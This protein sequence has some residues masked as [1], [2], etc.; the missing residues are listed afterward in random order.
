MAYQS[1]TIFS[2]MSNMI[3][4]WKNEWNEVTCTDDL[5][6]K[7]D[8]RDNVQDT[9][10][11][12]TPNPNNGNQS[13]Q[14]IIINGV[15]ITANQLLLRQAVIK[16]SIPE[17]EYKKLTTQERLIIDLP[18]IMVKLGWLYS[19]YCQI[20]WLEASGSE[21][22]VP[23]EFVTSYTRVQKTYRSMLN[24]FAQMEYASINEFNSLVK[25]SFNGSA[26]N[27]MYNFDV[28]SIEI[29]YY[30][31]V[32]FLKS[33][34]DFG[35]HI[36]GNFDF[37]ESIPKMNFVRSYVLGSYTGDLDDLG[38]SFG[39]FSLRVYVKGKVQD[40]NFNDPNYR[41][42]HFKID[43]IGF[44]YID[45][46]SFDDEQPLG[47]WKYDLN[48][49]ELPAKTWATA[50]FSWIKLSNSDYRRLKSRGLN[51]GAD[52]ILLTPFRY[53]TPANGL[54]LKPHI[55]FFLRNE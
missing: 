49:P 41:R 20:H 34:H 17:N 4:F 11:D 21:V 30:K 46:F 12:Y 10:N 28:N 38:G 32:S 3:D 45:E 44:R 1:P 2:I 31:A 5:L 36:F 52:Y 39:K 43:E 14:V 25:T 13:S 6:D 19:A 9:E 16:Q 55:I 54:N 27:L 22:V 35:E 51:L 53:L 26:Y 8:I 37:N 47:R 33:I 23:H 7:A 29:A 18:I 42:F 40:Q 15:T 50:P 24:N 48:N